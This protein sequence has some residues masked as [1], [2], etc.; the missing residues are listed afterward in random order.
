MKRKSFLLMISLAISLIIALTGKLEAYSVDF[1]GAIVYH[2]DVAKIPFILSNNATNVVIWTDSY[3]AGNFDPII[4]VWDGSSNLIG[5]ND[6]IDTLNGIW[7]CRVT[8][9]SLVAGSYLLT[10]ASYD[11]NNLGSTLADG[12][13]RDNDPPV[14]IEQWW[15][16]QPGNWSAHITANMVPIPAAVWLFGSG[17]IGLIFTR[18]KFNR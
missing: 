3:A 15:V 4:A 16:E 18:K 14:P 7:D 10:I 6:D 17:I 13:Y 8:F 11:N 1:S 12:F 5:E 9:A 2:N